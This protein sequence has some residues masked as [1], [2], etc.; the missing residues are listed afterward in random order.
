MELF[1]QATGVKLLHVPY[2]GTGPASLALIGGDVQIGFNN[3][4]TLLQYVR[5][6]QLVP[7]AVAEPRRMPA[8]PDVPTVAET[9]PGFEMAP[10]AGIIAPVKTPK[11]ITDKLAEA[12]LTVMRQPEVNALLEDQQVTAMPLSSDQF[13]AM[14]RNDLQKWEKVIKTANIKGI[15]KPACTACISAPSRS[16]SA[17]PCATSS[18]RGQA[19]RAQG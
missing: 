6:G 8:L 13:A 11:A 1:M 16:K 14:I 2:R 3:V 17:T 9:V 5:A 10:W 15:R 4:L 19:G 18:R 7:L 12:T